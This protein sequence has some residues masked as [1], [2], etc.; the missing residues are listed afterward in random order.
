MS[1]NGGETLMQA[2]DH[3]LTTQIYAFS[4]CLATKQTAF[5]LPLEIPFS[6]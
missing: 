5:L 1:E 6:E 3:Y 4:Y 2:S